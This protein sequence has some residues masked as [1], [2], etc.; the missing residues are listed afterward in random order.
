MI[1]RI[2]LTLVF[3][4]YS[5]FIVDKSNYN[6]YK[7]DVIYSKPEIKYKRPKIIIKKIFIVI[8]TNK[9][10]IKLFLDT[11][12]MLESSNRWDV[13]KK[14]AK[15][16]QNGNIVYNNIYK[17]N[18]WGD[19]IKHKKEIKWVCYFG[20]YQIGNSSL[21]ELNKHNYITYKSF[22]KDPNIWS[23]KEQDEDILILMKKN[24]Y[25]LRNYDKFIG[26]KIKGIKINW[27]SLLAA[28]HLVGNKNVKIFL[29]S[30]GKIDPTDGNGIKCSRYMRKFQ[31]YNFEI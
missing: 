5:L 30:K 23:E 4:I 13:I 6:D 29:D 21:M 16:N 31:Y 19:T 26:R 28:S 2:L 24:K 20:K 15:L 27:S 22:N 8:D 12:A 11:L 3:I 10:K 18:K 14:T 17:I 1:R 9:I 25:Y 7:P